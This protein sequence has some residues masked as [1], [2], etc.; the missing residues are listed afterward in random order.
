MALDR[1][2]SDPEWSQLRAELLGFEEREPQR[3]LL[4]PTPRS[5]LR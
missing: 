3:L 2:E 5:R 4:D 1:L